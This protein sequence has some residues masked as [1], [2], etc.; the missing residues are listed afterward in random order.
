MGTLSTPTTLGAVANESFM[1][2][3]LS[4][5]GK[6]PQGHLGLGSGW[7]GSDTAFFPWKS[8]RS[9]PNFSPLLT[10]PPLPFGAVTPRSELEDRRAAALSRAPTPP[11]H[12]AQRTALSSLF[13]TDELGTASG[14]S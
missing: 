14:A 5:S 1:K 12:L 11:A 6:V 8:P 10:P 13:P 2:S 4:W 3:E 7:V 9:S